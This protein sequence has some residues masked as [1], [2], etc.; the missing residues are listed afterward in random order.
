[1]MLRYGHDRREATRAL[2]DIVQG[3]FYF[4]HDRIDDAARKEMG[5]R[6]S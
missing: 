6:L 4:C 1:M 5:F 2:K 3:L